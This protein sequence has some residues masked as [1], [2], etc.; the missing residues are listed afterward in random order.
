M[1]FYVMLVFIVHISPGRGVAALS[2]AYCYSHV[3]SLL[4]SSKKRLAALM[5]YGR[6]FQTLVDKEE[7]A[8]PPTRA[9]VRG[10]WTKGSLAE[11]GI[12]VGVWNWMPLLR[13]AG[14]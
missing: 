8:C 1:L 6:S 13:Y 7:K 4:W 12:L 14:P 10:T 11:W 3:F 5:W 9:Q 2:I